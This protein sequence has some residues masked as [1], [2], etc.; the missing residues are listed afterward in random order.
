[1]H[2]GLSLAFLYISSMNKLATIPNL[3]EL[4]TLPQ[5]SLWLANFTSQRTQKTYSIAIR[6]FLNFHSIQILEDLRAVSVGHLI[7]WR[8]DLI[9]SGA[10]PCT[11]NNRLSAMSSLCNH[12]CE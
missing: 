10:T 5:E 7:T 9:E 11:V 3:S 8:D 12:L 2:H 1:M 4:V 6:E